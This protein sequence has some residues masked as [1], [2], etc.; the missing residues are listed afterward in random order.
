MSRPSRNHFSVVV[1]GFAMLCLVSGCIM[2][3]QIHQQR[4]MQVLHQDGTALVVRTLNG[5]VHVNKQDGS[6][7]TIKA[8]LV[9]QWQERLDQAQVLA[10]RQP[11]GALL[12]EVSFPG[13]AR[14]SE[15]SSFEIGIPAASGL[16]LESHNGGLAIAG[17]SGRAKLSTSNGGIDVT[18]HR[19]PVQAHTSNGHIV[20]RAV[21]GDAAAETTNGHVEITGITGAANART[22]NG[23]VHV[24]LAD[25]S[26]GPVTVQTS[27]GGVDLTLGKSFVGQL[28]MATSNGGVHFK[29]PP[30]VRYV[31]VE[32]HSAH[33][34]IGH[35]EAVSRIRTT[36]GSIHVH[37]SE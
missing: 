33:L 10:T 34:T 15:G 32:G 29:S 8:D 5:S 27:N 3:P 9:S 17:L 2:R 37:F 22:S 23:T 4:T 24:A 7:V 18:D 14:S 36:N 30:T 6:Q 13:G 35:S 21:A 20:L 11:D 16:D 12:I 25:A 28:D 26:P 19:G 1:S 31:S